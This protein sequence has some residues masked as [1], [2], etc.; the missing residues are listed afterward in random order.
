MALLPRLELP[1][2]SHLGRAGEAVH[3]EHSA[4]FLAERA[5]KSSQRNCCGLRAWSQR[6]RVF[7]ACVLVIVTTTGNAGLAS[8]VGRWW[9]ILLDSTDQEQT[10]R[11]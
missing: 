7:L 10:Q 3:T 4:C 1:A 2:W 5:R 9:F 11:V 8:G 6:T